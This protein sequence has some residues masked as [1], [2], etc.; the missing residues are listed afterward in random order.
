MLLAS[1][2]VAV[3]VMGPGVMEL[4]AWSDGAWSLEIGARSLE[5]GVWW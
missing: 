2:N 1:E 5:I 3:Y 4:G